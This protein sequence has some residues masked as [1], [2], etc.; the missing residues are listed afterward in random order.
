MRKIATFFHGMPI[1][2]CIF[3]P[4]AVSFRG[5]LVSSEHSQEDLREIGFLRGKKDVFKDM[6][7]KMRL[8]LI[9]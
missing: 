2:V 8:N 9:I 3:A 5:S 6:A 1:A 7:N 4:S